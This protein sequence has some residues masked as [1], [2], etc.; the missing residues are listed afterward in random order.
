MNKESVGM[1][2]Q[3]SKQHSTPTCPEE[4][5]LGDDTQNDSATLGPGEKT[6]LSLAK[7]IP[8]VILIAGL[9]AF[10]ALTLIVIFP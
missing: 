8:V 10:F 7:L 5:T 9:V 2:V 4:K 3:A 6:V 1:A